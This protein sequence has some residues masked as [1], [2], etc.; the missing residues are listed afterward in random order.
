M[1]RIARL[2]VPG[3]PHHIIQ[4][5][6]R[7]QKVFFKDED[8]KIYLEILKVQCLRFGV[9]IWSYCLMDNHVHF[10]AVPE[11]KE[12]LGRA[13][14]QT[15]RHYTR[16]INFR[17]GWRGYL[18]QGRFLSYVLDQDYLYA[19][20]RYIETNP[21]KAAIVAKAEDYPWSSAKAR[22]LKL[23]DD[24]LS[25]FFLLEEIKDWSSY[26]ASINEKETKLFESRLS[27]GKPLGSEEFIRKLEQLTGRIVRK[28][29]PGP[30]PTQ[31]MMS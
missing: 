5:G 19:A 9:V 4:R 8:K 22:V 21:I 16:M 3:M 2:V 10:V 15:H 26:L 29:K 27:S 17:E 23:K 1:P 13:F 31:T 12:S 11:D 7:R 18:W 25:D 20:V 28:I 14:G 24:L 30:K 6:N